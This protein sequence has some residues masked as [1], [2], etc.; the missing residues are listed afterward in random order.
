M[1][2]WKMESALSNEQQIGYNSDTTVY[3]LLFCIPS[4]ALSSLRFY[5]H[6]V[7]IRCNVTLFMFIWTAFDYILKFDW[8]SPPHSVESV[9]SWSSVG[10]HSRQCSRS[11]V[12]SFLYERLRAPENMEWESTLYICGYF[13]LMNLDFYDKGNTFAYIYI[14]HNVIVLLSYV[15]LLLLRKLYI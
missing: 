6:C 5:L 9:P 13:Y 7:H 10:K 12:R 11:S 1:V 8:W 14:T 2:S 3:M 4:F 15:S